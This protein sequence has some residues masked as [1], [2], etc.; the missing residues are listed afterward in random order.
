MRLVGVVMG[1]DTPDNRTSDTVKLLNYGFNSYKLSTIYE[2]DK[3]IDEI[4]V[5]KGKIDSV[6][7]ILMDNA[8]ELLNIND[9]IKTYTINVKLDKIIAPVKKNDK[10]GVAQIIDNEGNII[11]NVGI[12]VKD[13][14][15]KANLW[16]YFKRNLNI[17]FTGKIVIK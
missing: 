9:K 17:T 2:K 10:V 5:E 13:D 12:T 14:V 3:V 7:I 11:T 16:D 6:K 1:V 8:T 15:E 4:R